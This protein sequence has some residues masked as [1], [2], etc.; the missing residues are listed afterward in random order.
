MRKVF[1]FSFLVIFV[2]PLALT[3]AQQTQPAAMKVTPSPE[4]KAAMKLY[5][6][7][8]YAAAIDAFQKVAESDPSMAPAANY[9]AGYAHYVMRHPAEAQASFGKTYSAQPQFDPR[10]YFHR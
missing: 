1:A 4:F 8:R 3:F 7:K 6:Q 9:F 2:F 5:W 10:P